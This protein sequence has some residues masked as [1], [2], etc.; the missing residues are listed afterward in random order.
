MVNYQNSKIYKIVDN[1]NGNIYIGSTIKTLSQRIAQH[2][3]GYKRFQAG[4]SN[5]CKSYDIIKNGDYDIVLLENC[6]NIET[7]EQLH[8]RERH[9]IDT[10]ECVNK[11]R[12][13]KYNELGER[14]YKK[15]WYEA[16]K[17]DI[18]KQMKQ[19]YEMNKEDI[20]A[21]MKEYRETN[22]EIL[23][24]KQKQKMNEK[25]TCPHCNIEFSRGNKSH[26]YNSEKHKQNT[27]NEL[28]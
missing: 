7:K 23:N 24:D 19:Y 25:I 15:E 18:Q 2:R 28:N 17:E 22:K 3:S 5:N 27:N 9:Y 20:I 6:E 13:G 1:T 26:H 10:L 8:A 14:E 21:K 16:N 12:P 4:K 11:N